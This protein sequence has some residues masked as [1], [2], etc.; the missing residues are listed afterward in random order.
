MGYR[1]HLGD[2]ESSMRCIVISIYTIFFHHLCIGMQACQKGN[3]LN[4][5]KCYQKYLYRHV[6][7]SRKVEIEFPKRS[8]YIDKLRTYTRLRRSIR[9]HRQR[10]VIV[11]LLQ[12]AKS[13]ATDF[14]LSVTTVA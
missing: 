3:T 9:Y 8:I 10:D 14:K 11:S 13:P 2:I 4:K 7:K 5:C 12:F 6:S 1:C